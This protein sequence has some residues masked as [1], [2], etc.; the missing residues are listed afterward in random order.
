MSDSIAHNPGQGVNVRTPAGRARRGE[1]DGPV[2]REGAA[3]P[4]PEGGQS[5]LGSPPAESPLRELLRIAGPTVAT[6]TSF[7]IM[8]FVDKILVS[9]IGPEPIYVGA[10]GNGGLAAWVPIALAM[11]TLSVINTYVAQNFGAG[12]PQRGPAYAWNGMWMGIVF[13]LLFLIPYGLALPWVF[14]AARIDP[15]QAQMAATYGQI[16]IFGSVIVLSARAMSHFFYGMHRAGVIMVASLIANAVNIALSW[17]LIFGKFGLPAMGVAGSAIGTVIATGI[18]LALPL[19]LF[20]SPAMNRLYRTR[21]AWRFSRAHVKDLVRIGWPGGAM[22][23]N[24]MVCWAF[25]MVYLVSHFGAEHATAGWIAHQYMSLSFMPAVGLSVACTAVV[26]KYMGMGRPDL[27]AH[28]SWLA[29]KLALGYMC[30]CAVLFVVF[31]RPMIGLFISGETPAELVE[32]VVRLGAL[33]LIATAAFQA[34]DAIAMIT[35][36][37]LRGAGDTV[38]PGIITIVLSW[39]LIVGGGLMMVWV[40]PGLESLGPWIA[41]SA[42]IIILSFFL[43]ARFMGGHWRTIRLMQDVARQDGPAEAPTPTGDKPADPPLI[44]LGSGAAA[45]AGAA[46]E[47]RPA[48]I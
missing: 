36:G 47:P 15:A 30:L 5:H 46:L 22:F 27:A 21:A 8:Q 16:L 33:F 25:F 41:A 2:R 26:G 11:G 35:S 18:E 31:R 32:Q 34:F 4:L 23:G 13:Y 17:A 6:M 9:R 39:V 43:L 19:A 20:L 3:A 24:E 1:T 42:Y 7:T 45:P 38:V 12:K 28:R 10:Q 37:A 40:F 29:L 44:R 48:D 14:G